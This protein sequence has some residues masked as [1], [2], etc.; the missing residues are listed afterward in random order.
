MIQAKEKPNRS[1][2]VVLDKDTIQIWVRKG[3][4]SFHIYFGDNDARVAG[5]VKK[6]TKVEKKIYKYGGVKK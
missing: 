3:D 2:E 4:K 5:W 1:A 6:G